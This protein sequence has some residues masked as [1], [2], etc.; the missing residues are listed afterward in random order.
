MDGVAHEEEFYQ[1]GDPKIED[2]DDDKTP[3]APKRSRPT[4]P[5]KC[6]LFRRRSHDVGLNYST[7][8]KIGKKK[9]TIVQQ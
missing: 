9:N 5:K 2:D 1:Y 3:Y 4:L 7:S 6:I 8:I